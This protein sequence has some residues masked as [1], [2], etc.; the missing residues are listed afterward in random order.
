MIGALIMSDHWQFIELKTTRRLEHQILKEIFCFQMQLFK[1]RFIV[2]HV[3]TYHKFQGGWSWVRI[4]APN[5]CVLIMNCA[6]APN[7][8][9]LIMYCAPN[10]RLLA[11]PLINN[12]T[13][14]E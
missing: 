4:C 13:M 9:V 3:P 7:I 10:I 11:P 8:C 6:C 2:D 1:T 12:R 5:I 14:E